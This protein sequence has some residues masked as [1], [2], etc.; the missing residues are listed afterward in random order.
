MELA[1]VITASVSLMSALTDQYGPEN[2]MKFWDTIRDTLPEEVSHGILMQFLTTDITNKN[3]TL[4]S[5]NGQNKVEGIK[6]IRTVSGLGLKHAMDTY[7]AVPC[8]LALKEDV[9][10][11]AA[12]FTLRAAGFTVG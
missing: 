1:P 10:Y 4:V 7:N 6:A 11:H 12:T 8:R 3:I 9:T 5:F 2:G